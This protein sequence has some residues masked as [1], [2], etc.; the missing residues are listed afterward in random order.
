MAFT[1]QGI[2]T[3]FYGQR[4]FHADGSFITTEWFVLI[5][6]P[7]IPL[8]SFR[9]K[10][11]GAEDTGLVF[12]VYYQKQNYSIYERKFPSWKQVLYTYSFVIFIILWTVLMI[13]VFMLVFQKIGEIFATLLIIPL[14]GFAAAIPYI[15]RYFAWR[16]LRHLKI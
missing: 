7:V 16:K 5:Y 15:L 1:F 4:D 3:T 10:S 2:G 8:R 9:V 13:D 12:P 6:F 11:K 14:F